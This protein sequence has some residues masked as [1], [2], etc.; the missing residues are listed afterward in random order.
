M[1]SL[2]PEI[3]F[4]N[5][6][7]FG[8][9]PISVQAE[10]RR[11]QAELEREPVDF[12][13]RK[14]P[15]LLERARQSAAALVGA[16]PANLA[17]TPNA[18]TGINAVLNSVQLRPDDEILTTNHRY[19]AVRNTLERRAQQTGARV[20]EA[21]LPFPET[22]VSEILDAIATHRTARTRLLV[23]D[24]ITS[25]TA[26]ALPIKD[27]ISHFKSPELRVLVDGAHAPGHIPVDLA[28]LGADWWVG[29]LHKW[30]C[31]PK[32]AALVW[33]ADEHLASLENPVTSHGWRNGLHAEFDW[34]GTQFRSP[35]NLNALFSALSAVP[36]TRL[37]GL[38][39]RIENLF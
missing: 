1:F 4:L 24:A 10:Q 19:D 17:F 13:V 39:K 18:T 25:P 12:L 20:V 27:I 32:G 3:T 36:V 30:I 15:E 14:L 33:C 2:D 8:A 7:S 38:E 11:L 22:T 23:I 28:T 35:P 21:E 34:T 9:T 16:A 6:G 26:M 31:A 29:N 37:S 5:H